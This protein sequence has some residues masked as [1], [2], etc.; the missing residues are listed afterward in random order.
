MILSYWNLQEHS[1]TIQFVAASTCNP[2]SLPRCNYVEL[3][4]EQNQKYSQ[5]IVRQGL[6]DARVGKHSE[7]IKK[8]DSAIEM[9]AENVE[10]LISRGISFLNIHKFEEA[11]EDLNSALKISPNNDTAL[12][13]LE[14][15]KHK[16]DSLKAGNISSSSIASNIASPALGNTPPKLMVKKQFKELLEAG[17]FRKGKK[18]DFEFEAP[19]LMGKK[20]RKE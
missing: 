12:R 9:D 19:D 11:L 7:A 6:N 13:Y 10:A 20:S 14:I 5:E 15:T 16:R 18:Y 2:T 17:T 4:N 1:R 8:F 3:R